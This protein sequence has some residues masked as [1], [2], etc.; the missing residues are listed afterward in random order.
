MKPLLFGLLFSVS[1]VAQAAELKPFTTDGCSMFPDGTLK[2]NTLWVDCCVRHDLA[3]WKGG[4]YQDRLAADEQL[5]ACVAEIG[6]PEIAEL[7]RSGVRIGGSPYFP[8]TYRWGYGWP[9]LR[10]YKTL[11]VEEQAQV[12][13]RLG[14]LRLILESLEGTL[15]RETQ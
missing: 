14:E 10:G 11:N 5:K 8:T 15:D 7:M 1:L 12:H 13:Q 4:S 3:Y 2:Q 6:E 9:Y